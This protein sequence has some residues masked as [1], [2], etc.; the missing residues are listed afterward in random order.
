LQIDDTIVTKGLLRRGLIIT[1]EPSKDERDKA[2]DQSFNSNDTGD[3]WDQWISYLKTLKDKEY[4]WSFDEEVKGKINELTRRLIEQGDNK[5]KKGSSYT[6]IMFFTLRNLLVKMSCIQAV[7]SDRSEVSIVDVVNAYSDL[8]LFWGIQLD[9]VLH[10]VKGDIDYLDITSKEKECLLILQSN[11]C[12]S[13]KDSNL[14]IKDYINLI[15]KNLD[16]SISSARYYYNKLVERGYVVGQ[17]TGKHSSRVWLTE[18]G[19]SKVEP[20]KTLDTLSTLKPKL[21][22][23]SRLLGK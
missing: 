1:C 17:Q 2:L 15:M 13:E 7:I 23:L 21:S 9:F 3:Y 8:T 6:D 22:I 14:M 11:N 16:C 5:G 19:L 10:K 18:I 4:N 20:Y 12:S